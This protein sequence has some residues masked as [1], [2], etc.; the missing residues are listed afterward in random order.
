V[1]VEQ[2]TLSE[3]FEQLPQRSTSIKNEAFYKIENKNEDVNAEYAQFRARLAIQRFSK[4][5]KLGYSIGCGTLDLLRMLSV[6]GT[7]SNADFFD[8]RK[9]NTF[10]SLPLDSMITL[11]YPVDNKLMT[12]YDYSIDGSGKVPELYEKAWI[13]FAIYSPLLLHLNLLKAAIARCQPWQP[14]TKFERAFLYYSPPSEPCNQAAVIRLRLRAISLLKARLKSPAL[15]IDDESIAAACYMI[16][17][18]VSLYL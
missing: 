10:P 13:P 7:S 9:N 18:E 16:Y 12:R 8:T 6:E 15:S 1:V 4:L 5:S 17:L 11:T 3:A 2:N 14:K